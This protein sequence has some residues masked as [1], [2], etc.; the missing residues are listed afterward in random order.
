[1]NDKIR[2]FIETSYNEMKETLIEL[3]KNVQ[4]GKMTAEEFV[5]QRKNLVNSYQ[6]KRKEMEENEI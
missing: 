4:E 6:S 1:M 5:K 3:N 2:E